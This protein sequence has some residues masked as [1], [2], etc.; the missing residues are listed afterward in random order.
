MTIIMTTMAILADLVYYQLRGV[1][2]GVWRVCNGDRARE[3]FSIVVNDGG[4]RDVLQR[5]D[6]WASVS[7]QHHKEI[8]Q[9][10]LF[11]LEQVVYNI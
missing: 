7:I 4:V 10:S 2:D 1:T 3:V 11:V 9:V 6:A 5:E 8:F